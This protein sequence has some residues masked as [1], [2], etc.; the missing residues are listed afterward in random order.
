MHC[1]ERTTAEWKTA[2]D[3]RFNRMSQIPRA[4]WTS[5]FH[6][7]AICEGGPSKMRGDYRFEKRSRRASASSLGINSRFEGWTPEYGWWLEKR[8][9][10]MEGCDADGYC[11]CTTL[12]HP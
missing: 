2:S 8:I 1:S 9:R 10:T 3:T 6:N 5:T 11:C 7:I 12:V 4:K